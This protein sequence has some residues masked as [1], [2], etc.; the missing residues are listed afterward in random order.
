MAVLI[1][2]LFYHVSIVLL[3]HFVYPARAQTRCSIQVPVP[4]LG[5]CE[6]V[7]ALEENTEIQVHETR[8]R[9]SGIQDYQEDTFKL[10]DDQ[11]TKMVNQTT[12]SDAEIKDI[13]EEIATMKR[14]LAHV[15]TLQAVPGTSTSTNSSRRGKRAVTSLSP[16]QQ[17]QL[18]AANTTFQNALADV[19]QKL[20][21]ISKTLENDEKNSQALHVRLQQEIAKNQRA[22][23]ILEQQLLVVDSTIKATL[24][25][26][27]SGNDKLLIHV[28][29]TVKVK[30]DVCPRNFLF[31]LVF[32]RK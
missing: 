21:N 23:N 28:L 1:R 20:Q 17:N 29:Q 26:G 10:F 22:L 18:D 8:G 12:F 5:Y 24:P 25:R 30:N 31:Y 9:I 32:C 11:F 14:V 15:Q 4:D 13:E 16:G 2:Q 7:G 3:L 6:A 19:L 27:S